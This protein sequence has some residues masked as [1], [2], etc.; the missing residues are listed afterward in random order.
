MPGQY[1]VKCGH[2]KS[3]SDRFCV[4]CGSAAETLPPAVSTPWSGGAFVALIIASFFLPVV[5]LGCGI[6][7]MCVNGKR[8]QGGWLF[9]VAVLS[10]MIQSA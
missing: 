7:G 4:K 3:P 8:T 5:G 2:K 6:W 1:C 10:F 9:G